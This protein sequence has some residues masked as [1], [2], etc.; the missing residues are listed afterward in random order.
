MNQFQWIQYNEFGFVLS[1]VKK[2][3]KCMLQEKKKKIQ[4]Y[5]NLKIDSF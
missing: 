4:T 5:Q 2:S 1:G 3:N